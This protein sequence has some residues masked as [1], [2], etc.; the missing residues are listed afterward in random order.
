MHDL[1]D[2]A[3]GKYIILEE[4]GRGGMGAVY[5]AR[6]VELD[7]IVAIKVL[8]PYLVGEPR[9]V[10]R[11]IREARLAAN[12]D[13]PNI[14]TIYDIGGEGGY[15]YF[16][17]K[18]LDGRPLK[19][20][21]A[22]RGPLPLEEVVS[23][24]QQ[25]ASAL[26]YA[27]EQTLVHRDIKPGNVMI[28][29]EGHVTLTDFGLAKVAETL[30]LT[31]SG[32]A[33]G[34]LEYMSPE[35]ARGDVQKESDIYSLGVII[36]EMLAGR[37]P[38]QGNNQATLLYQHLHD[39]P[40]SL[41]QWRPDAP[42]QIDQII[43]KAMAKEPAERYA[44]A[45][46]LSRDLE[47]AIR[48]SWLPSA[49]R[50]PAKAEG[51]TSPDAPRGIAPRPRPKLS[52][53]LRA[54]LAAIAIPPFLRR[55]GWVI[56]T[57]AVVL[58]GLTV[59]AILFFGD[60]QGP[61]GPDL[62]PAAP[63]SGYFFPLVIKSPPPPPSPSPSPTPPIPGA[64]LVRC[65]PD[66]VA[67]SDHLALW[68][69]KDQQPTPWAG[70][71]KDLVLHDLAWSP[72]GAWVAFTAAHQGQVDLYRMRFNGS[73]M[74]R[75]T[76][77]PMEERE[78]AWSPDGSHIVFTANVQGDDNVFLLPLEGGT[79][80]LLV[81][82]PADDYSPSWGPDGRQLV[83]VS[84]RDGNP[85]IYRIDLD[86]EG[87]RVTR[88]TNSPAHDL[89]PVWSPQGSRIAFLSDRSGEV[90]LYQIDPDGGNLHLLLDRPAREEPP[91]WSP[92]GDWIGIARDGPGKA[93]Q[94]HVI[95]LADERVYEGPSGCH[96]PIWRPHP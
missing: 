62:G 3:L 25:L 8:S 28:T 20:I 16:A 39:P 74:T 42:P 75:M 76:D 38:F 40:P 72:D 12:L 87:D 60:R 27:H 85:E 66:E 92:Q 91:T 50:L 80:D 22:E 52:R 31:A 82:D 67:A 33:I 36:Y 69:G 30:K 4:I 73:N 9:L 55:W 70:Q 46:E 79:P 84:E 93:P 48:T 78:P 81:D 21:L 96:R 63:A 17:M 44:T 11:F 7:R 19:D 77:S 35:Q 14:V 26:D 6:D 37:L 10:Q 90:Q 71:P 61:N 65:S 59:G 58:A 53:S 34:T 23:V 43:Q 95:D 2:R 18:Y 89:Y 51:R 64:L 68:S 41:Q 1:S 29:S 54:A 83:F 45:G 86:A 88:L 5:K 13:H 47:D 94:I 56:L 15:Y 24:T 49:S 57:A 32:E